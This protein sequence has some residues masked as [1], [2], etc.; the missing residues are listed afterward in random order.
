[1]AELAG[2]LDPSVLGDAIG[3]VSA[4]YNDADVL[5]E[6]NNHGHAVMVWVRSFTKA[7]LLRGRDGK[8]G[9]VTTP[10][11]KAL[12]YDKAADQFRAGNA[13]VRS[14]ETMQQLASIEGATLA[15]PEGRRDDRATAYVLA[16]AGLAFAG[17]GAVGESAQSEV[18][19][20]IE[21]AD[22]RGFGRREEDW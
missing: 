9:W 11:S 18:P 6:R 19:D 20:V 7:R 2:L 13:C 10:V 17:G 15:A 5:V 4:W 12:A 1:V 3:Q 16:L 14:V 21:Q 22:K 8:E